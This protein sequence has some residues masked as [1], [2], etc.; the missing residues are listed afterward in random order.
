MGSFLNTVWAQMLRG[1]ELDRQR[2]REDQIHADEM[3]RTGMRQALEEQRLIENAKQAEFDRHRRV[4][5]MEARSAALKGENTA[6]SGYFNE[7]VGEMAGAAFGAG[8]V[9]REGI[10]ADRRHKAAELDL[11]E[12]EELGR[13]WGRQIDAMSGTINSRNVQ[14]GG[15]AFNAYERELGFPEGSLTQT[16]ADAYFSPNDGG[17]DP[18]HKEFQA[19]RASLEAGAKG[20]E[21][22]AAF[23]AAGGLRRLSMDLTDMQSLGFSLQEAMKEI[24]L[25]RKA[26]EGLIE[27]AYS[28][29]TNSVTPAL[30]ARQPGSGSGPGSAEDDL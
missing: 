11:K 12:R 2:K 27:H 25:R 22:W 15:P 29:M 21:E 7:A 17:G 14:K 28:I 6:P 1:R 10:L 18:R 20:K 13:N 4:A 16:P 23:A 30:G 19:M 5:E 3:R 8:Q 26:P 24:A 9:E